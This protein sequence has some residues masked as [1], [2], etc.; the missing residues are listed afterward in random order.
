V[1]PSW[2]GLQLGASFAPESVGLWANGDNSA[3]A[4]GN[5]RAAN[6]PIQSELSRPK[7]MFEVAARYQGNLGPV[8]LD[9]M[10]GYLGSDVVKPGNGAAYT[11]NVSGY[12]G[13]SVFDAGMSLTYMGASVF[14][15]VSTGKM[16]GAATPVATLANG[17]KKDG[18]A[19][20]VGA[21]YSTGPYTIG[22]SWYQFDHQ[23]GNSAATGNK[24][25]K[26]FALGG[27]YT[28]VTGVDFFLEY[29]YGNIHQNGKNFVDAAGPTTSN[30]TA[31]TNMVIAS[32]LFR[33]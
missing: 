28:L 3:S 33:W 13:L 24:Q 19:W 16:D 14:G 22:T 2:G 31:K 26:G 20:V 6:S 11:A 15:H 30:N 29:L 21:Q 5:A 32:A 23:G 1:S 8:A 7:N 25:E 12:K 27:Q 10:A 17:R 4:G 9:V 18:I